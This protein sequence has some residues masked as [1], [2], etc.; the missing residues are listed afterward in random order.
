MCAG[1]RAAETSSYDASIHPL[2]LVRSSHE[3]YPGDASAVPPNQDGLW[4]DEGRNV[5][6][7][8]QAGRARVGSGRTDTN[9]LA[10][11]SMPSA[12]VSSVTAPTSVCPL[13]L[14]NQADGGQIHHHI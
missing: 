9:H 2:P 11:D 8:S 14:A 3:R 13:S 7:S 12:N 4:Q 1:S 6:S 10:T 5:S